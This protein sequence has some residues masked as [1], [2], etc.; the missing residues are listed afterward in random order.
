MQK[1]GEYLLMHSDTTRYG[2]FG[3]TIEDVNYRVDS[4]LHS[5]CDFA[6][7]QLLEAMCAR[8]AFLNV[9]SNLKIQQVAFLEQFGG[10]KIVH[11]HSPIPNVTH[12]NI[13]DVK[14]PFVYANGLCINVDGAMFMGGRGFIWELPALTKRGKVE[15]QYYMEIP[16]FYSLQFPIFLS[17]NLCIRLT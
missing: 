9:N 11:G 5:D 10:K 8:S 1:I 3:G 12:Q 13:R 7:M 4:V 6:W 2:E 17:V 15:E 16:A 14:Q